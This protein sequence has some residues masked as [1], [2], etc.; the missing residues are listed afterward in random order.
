[1]AAKKARA[2]ASNRKLAK[3]APAAPAGVQQ[4]VVV[5]G[6]PMAPA[7]ASGKAKVV[8][9]TGDEKK[10]KGT[11][12]IYVK[13]V[14]EGYYGHKRRRI[15]EVFAMNVG[16]GD[17]PEWVIA[18]EDAEPG[19]DEGTRGIHSGG[20]E[21]DRIREERA[22][23]TGKGFKKVVGKGSANITDPTIINDSVPLGEGGNERQPGPE[24]HVI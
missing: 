9:V 3:E 1:M 24:A 21:D 4:D 2:A 7:T 23:R 12:S 17:L 14:R 15:G 22:E 10:L 11:S 19:Q 8:D 5:T 6:R 13:A 20:R 16:K 18:L